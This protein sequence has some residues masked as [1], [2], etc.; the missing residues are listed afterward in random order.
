MSFRISASLSRMR[1]ASSNWS[2]RFIR[3]AL[4]YFDFEIERRGGVA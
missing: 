4:G 1:S 3:S 2:G